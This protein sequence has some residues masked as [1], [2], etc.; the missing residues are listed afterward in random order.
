M[1]AKSWQRNL[2]PHRETSKPAENIGDGCLRKFPLP[3]LAPL[4]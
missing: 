2:L 3:I 4:C 1:T